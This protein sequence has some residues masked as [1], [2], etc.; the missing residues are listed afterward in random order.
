[1][2]TLQNIFQAEIIQRLGWT[3]VH[4]V[5]QAIA[6][7]MILAIVLKLLHKSSANLRYLIA[8]MA[9][10]LIVLMPVV[11]IKM[12]D[13]SVE[14]IKPVEQ[15]AVDL[16]KAGVGAQAI[17]EMPQVE[18]PL[19]QVAA[20]PRVPLKDRFVDAI[21][22]VLPYIVVGWLIGVF[23]LSLWHLGGWTQLQRLRRQMVKQVTPTLKAK[24]QQLS[25]ALGI[26]ETVG[27]VESALVQ[28][29]TVVGHLKPVILLPASALTGLSP[30]QIEAILA[31][32]L[33]HIKRC[34]YLVNMLQTVVEILGFYHPAV[35]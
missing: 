24:L 27:L 22:P 7:G 1:M 3:L 20:S 33:A 31:H 12:V 10:A 19:A 21:E 17:V 18:P 28:V 16:P 26:R 2:E 5:W 6:I 35:W 34:D 8:C 23:G 30:E 13:V 32:E 15:T 29:P 4:F 25:K 9:L 11:T 14:T